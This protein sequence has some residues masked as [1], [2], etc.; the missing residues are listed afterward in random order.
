MAFRIKGSP[1]APAAPRRAPQIPQTSEVG[2]MPHA[3]PAVGNAPKPVR[4]RRDYGKTASAPGSA[5]QPSPFG[6]IGG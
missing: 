3:L 4:S 5:P 6:P 2:N 1:S